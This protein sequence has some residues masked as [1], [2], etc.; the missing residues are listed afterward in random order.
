MVCVAAIVCVEEVNEEGVVVGCCAGG[1]A[2]F[3]GDHFFARKS[4]ELIEF[5]ADK[6]VESLFALKWPHAPNWPQLILPKP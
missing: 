2:V 3:C 1:G 5:R 6:L 4:N